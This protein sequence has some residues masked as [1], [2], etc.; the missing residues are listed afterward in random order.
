MRCFQSAGTQQQQSQETATS[1]PLCV[2]PVIHDQNTNNSTKA[3]PAALRLTHTRCI[4]HVLHLQD[5]LAD[6]P[7]IQGAATR[8]LEKGTTLEKV[9]PAHGEAMQQRQGQVQTRVLYQLLSC[10]TQLQHMAQVSWPTCLGCCRFTVV[11]DPGRPV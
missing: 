7:V 8:A 5:P 9:R 4:T 10:S 11:I 3:L 6:G 2:K 1:H